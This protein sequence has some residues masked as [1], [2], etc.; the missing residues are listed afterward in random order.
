MKFVK[1]GIWTAL[2]P[3]LSVTTAAAAHGG[4]ENG[5]LLLIVLFFGFF[6]L[7]VV[8]QLIPAIV[9]FVGLIMKLFGRTEQKKKKSGQ[10]SI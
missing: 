10:T 2:L 8:F 1:C 9:H 7:I 4:E 5:S 6:A 3:L